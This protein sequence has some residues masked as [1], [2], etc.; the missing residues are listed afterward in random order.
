[1]LDVVAHPVS[2]G[3]ISQRRLLSSARFTADIVTHALYGHETNALALQFTKTRR[4]LSGLHGLKTI[5]CA[6]N[7]C[8]PA[9]LQQ[10]LGNSSLVWRN[11]YKTISSL[12][13][14]GIPEKNITVLST[15]VDINYAAVVT[16]TWDDL[17]V[18]ALVTAG[19][20]SNAIR[21]GKDETSISENFR[22]AGTINIIIE[23]NA[24]LPV[25]AMAASF[26]TATEAK[27]IALD[28][29][30]IKSTYSPEL[31]ATGTGTDT[32]LV[33]SGHGQKQQY[34]GGHTRLGHLMARA[35]TTA[36]IQALRNTN[37]L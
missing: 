10:E 19:T 2:A 29:L 15:G 14:P 26:I 37:G 17:Q 1:M 12:L 27:T 4:T 16:E 18:S 28:E 13:F 32:I 34:V 9:S 20:K 3:K 7:C 21:I 23:T 25:S 22:K 33:I 31:Q 5:N 30:G 24:S 11:Y 6:A 36:T 35:V 8:L